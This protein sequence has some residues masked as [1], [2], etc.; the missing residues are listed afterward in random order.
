MIR[1]LV[2]N[3]INMSVGCKERDN[4]VRVCRWRLCHGSAW[5]ATAFIFLYNNDTKHT[6]NAIKHDR[7]PHS[8]TLTVV[9]WPPQS[10]SSIEA[11]CD[12]LVCC[13]VL[14]NGIKG[15]EMKGGSRL[16]HSAMYW[17]WIVL[18]L[19][20]FIYWFEL[21]KW[22]YVVFLL[23]PQEYGIFTFY[24]LVFPLHFYSIYCQ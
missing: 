23:S 17:F 10:L 7:W 4:V 18:N 14:G 9:Y 12:Y 21:F 1:V 16:L 20:L 3:I 24:K 13:S 2:Q 8:G 15:K 6:A 11:V 22:K 5:L 19:F